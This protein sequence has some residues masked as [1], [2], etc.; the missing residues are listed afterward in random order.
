M[1]K[2]RMKALILI[3]ISFLLCACSSASKNDPHLLRKECLNYEPEKVQLEG[4]LYR[5]SFP[6]PPNYEDVK[7]GDEEEIYWLIS[8]VK[9]FCV[10]E[11]DQVNGNKLQNQ[12]Q[13]QLVIS[14]KLDFYHTKRDLLNK[15]VIVKGTLFPQM[16]GHHKTEVLMTV[17]SLEKAIK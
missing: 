7:K 10:Y 11:S 9:P 13:V 16:T 4:E 12:S 8:T 2:D 17:E 6:G 1:S 5:K 14:S 3:V 15:K